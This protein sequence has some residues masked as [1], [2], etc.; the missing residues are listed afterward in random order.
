MEPMIKYEKCD[1]EDGRSCSQKGSG[2][3][4]FG[5]P[6][7]RLQKKIAIKSTEAFQPHSLVLMMANGLDENST[8]KPAASEGV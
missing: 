8:R 3:D 4:C 6:S 5:P 1:N 7:S 2:I